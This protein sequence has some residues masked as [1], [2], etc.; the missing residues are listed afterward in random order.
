MGAG[1]FT[2]VAHVSSNFLD[3]IDNSAHTIHGSV[4]QSDWPTGLA[5]FPPSAICGVRASADFVPRTSAILAGDSVAFTNLSTGVPASLYQWDFGDGSPPSTAENPSHTYAVQGTF[6]VTLTTANL[7]NSDV[8]TDTVQAGSIPTAAFTPV[9]GVILP[10]ERVRFTN[11]SAG[12]PTPT[13]QWDFGDGSLP[14][15]NA[16]PGHTYADVGSYTVTLTATNLHGQ[17]VTTGTV[18]VAPY[19][20]YMPLIMYDSP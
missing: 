18:E 7:Y 1:S 16:N 6:T 15:T 5:L 2:Y 17:D 13:Y 9:P 3:V 11:T 19:A 4:P 10:G 8:A 12:L 20:Y 14:N